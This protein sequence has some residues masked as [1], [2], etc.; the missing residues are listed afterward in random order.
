MVWTMIYA[1]PRW[2]S[3]AERGDPW[4]P[5]GPPWALTQ[6]RPRLR[7]GA[8]VVFCIWTASRV[9]VGVRGFG[10]D[11][12]IARGAALDDA[13]KQ[14]VQPGGVPTPP[15]QLRVQWPVGSPHRH[16]TPHQP[17]KF[18]GGSGSSGSP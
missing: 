17:V 2:E 8:G 18:F 9:R 16:Q 10:D 13:G 3:R 15:W 14:G 4:G 12:T 11:R 5:Y 1:A 6:A 7:A